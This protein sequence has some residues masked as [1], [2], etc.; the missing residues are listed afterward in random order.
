MDGWNDLESQSDPRE[1]SRESPYQTFRIWLIS[2]VYRE[3]D[4]RPSPNPTSTNPG[5]GTSPGQTSPNSYHHSNLGMT[6][7]PPHQMLQL[8]ETPLGQG[9]LRPRSASETG[10]L[11]RH[12][13]RQLVGSLTSTYKFKEDGLVKKV[14]PHVRRS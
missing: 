4:K 1:L 13:E 5:M 12:R 14:R 9:A 8:P 3:T 11:N 2:Q 7:S 10:N 6:M